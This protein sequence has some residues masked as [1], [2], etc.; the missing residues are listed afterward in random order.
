M[1]D[2]DKIISELSIKKSLN[3]NLDLLIDYCIENHTLA[4]LL[5]RGN[6]TMQ[7]FSIISNTALNIIS[8][9]INALHR[10]VNLLVEALMIDFTTYS[11]SDK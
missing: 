11:L 1:L 3:A 6:H 10:Y 2:L 4:I 5:R 8:L 7:F 9:Y